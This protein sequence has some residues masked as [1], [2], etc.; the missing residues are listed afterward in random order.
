MHKP[1][2]KDIVIDNQLLHYYYLDAAP[3]KK[4]TVLFLHGWGSNS[5]LWFNSTSHLAEK[6]YELIYLDLPGFGKSQNPRESFHLDDYARI[7]S[8]FIE[9]LELKS[10]VLVGH[11]FGGKTGIRMS[12]KQLV[13]LSGLVL[14][15]SS[16]LPHTSLVTKTKIQIAKTVKPIMDLPFMQGIRSNLLRFSGSDDYIASPQLRETF[17][18]V[19]SEHIEFE[20]PKIETKT[21]IIWGGDDENSYTPV[22]DVSVFHRLIKGAEAHIIEKAGHYCFLDA[23]KEFSETLLAFLESRNGKS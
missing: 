22:S 14:V 10:P 20:L 4:K 5:T 21:L 2:E 1:E 23:P 17:V 3:E 9:K 16:G 7:V 19:V 8:Q 13:S 12:S 18:N 11:S 15:D 6:G